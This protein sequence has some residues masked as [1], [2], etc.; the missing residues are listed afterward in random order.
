MSRVPEP[1]YAPARRTLRSG[2]R[3]S[4]GPDGSAPA[5]TRPSSL[6]RSGAP[7][8]PPAWCSCRM[9]ASKRPWYRRPSRRGR[10][11]RISPGRRTWAQ[12]PPEALSFI[13]PTE[14]E[15]I[16]RGGATSVLSVAPLRSQAGDERRQL[17]RVDGL[18]DVGVKAGLERE[19]PVFRP[20]VRRQCQGADLATLVGT[21]RPYLAD[22]DVSVVTRHADVAD[23]YVRPPASQRFKRFVGRAHH[24]D[25]RP[26]LAENLGEEV[27]RVG[28]IVHDQDPSPGEIDQPRG[29]ALESP[30]HGRG[31]RGRANVVGGKRELDHQRRS[32]AFPLALRPHSARVELHDMAHD[33]ETEPEAPMPSR[34]VVLPEAVE[35]VREKLPADA[36]TG[37][38]DPEA[39]VRA[40]SFQAEVDTASAGGELDRVREKV[41]HHLLQSTGVAHE[42]AGRRIEHGFEADALRVRKPLDGLDRRLDDGDEVDGT[43]LEPELAGYDPGDIQEVVDELSQELGVPLDLRQG[44][45]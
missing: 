45:R 13:L 21:Q 39:C 43:G 3:C 26:G 2:W 16:R 5:P 9:G 28:L 6:A 31:F 25:L 7:I 18:G 33:R 29:G 11:T 24:D 42:R 17:E 27:P 32:S 34:P 35:D 10:P 37:I 19:R 36:P 15:L 20:R 8:R 12:K 44:A 22:Q 1:E 38:A 30:V 41:P 4:L 40:G 23:Q 14:R